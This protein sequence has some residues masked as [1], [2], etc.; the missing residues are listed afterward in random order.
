MVTDPRAVT[1]QQTGS[2]SPQAFMMQPVARRI[3]PAGR[4]GAYHGHNT[5]RDTIIIPA[6]RSSACQHH[7]MWEPNTMPCISLAAV[8]PD[9]VLPHH[10]L[11]VTWHVQKFCAERSITHIATARQVG[12]GPCKIDS[13]D[14]TDVEHTQKALRR[15]QLRYR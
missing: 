4:R 14:C 6:G 12:V 7:C 11:P 15:W 8:T 3:D 9:R 5:S 13:N 10:A 2:Y 1:R